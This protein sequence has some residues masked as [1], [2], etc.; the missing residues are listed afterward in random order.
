[1]FCV[2]FLRENIITFDGMSGSVVFKKEFAVSNVV[3][4]LTLNVPSFLVYAKP[5]CN[6]GEDD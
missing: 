2:F 4:A 3:V 6:C 1:M 5:R